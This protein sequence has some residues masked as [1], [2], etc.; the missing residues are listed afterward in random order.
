MNCKNGHPRTPE[1]VT[2][3]RQCKTCLYTYQRKYR[4]RAPISDFM[5]KDKTRPAYFPDVLMR[6]SKGQEELY[7]RSREQ[8][9]LLSQHKYAV[10]LR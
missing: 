1:N 9:K 3:S 4:Q 6:Q 8:I 7:R 2:S 5:P 10:K